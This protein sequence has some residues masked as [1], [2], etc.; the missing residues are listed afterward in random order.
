MT[1]ARDPSI[2]ALLAA[3]RASFAESLPAKAADIGALVARGV[4]EDARRAAHK[5]R[6]SAGT[7][8]FVALGAAAGAI[9]ELLIEAAGAP[10][11]AARSRLDSLLTEALG[12]ARRAGKEGR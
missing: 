5:L 11:G 1:G 9:E 7:Y 8:G 10:E 12:E 2:D 4:W 3:A 6:G